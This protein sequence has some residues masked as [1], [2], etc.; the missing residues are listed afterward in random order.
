MASGGSDPPPQEPT[1]TENGV[2]NRRPG[3]DRLKGFN[4]KQESMAS[5]PSSKRRILLALMIVNTMDAMGEFLMGVCFPY[6]M[7]PPDPSVPLTQEQIDGGYG[8][9]AN[10]AVKIG[11][12][13]AMNLGPQFYNAGQFLSSIASG[14]LARAIG[15]RR[16][17]ILYTLGGCVGMVLAGLSKDWGMWAFFGMRMLTG[18]FGGSLVVVTSLVVDVSDGPEDQESNM[19]QVVGPTMILGLVAGPVIG[20][21]IK[22]PDN[23]RLFWPLYIGAI[24][25]FI[26]F[27][28]VFAII[29]D[30]PKKDTQ[31]E[32]LFTKYEEDEDKEDRTAKVGFTKFVAIFWLACAMDTA[33]Q[34]AM[35]M[36]NNV[37]FHRFPWVRSHFTEVIII[38]AVVV[39]LVMPLSITMT[40]FLGYAYTAIVGQTL[41][42]VCMFVFYAIATTNS[43][44]I[45]PFMIMFYLTPFFNTIS[46]FN[47][48]NI[49][50]GLVPKK[51]AD[52]WLGYMD[53]FDQVLQA[54]APFLLVTF[55]QD[56][57]WGPYPYDVCT[58]LPASCTGTLAERYVALCPCSWSKDFGSSDNFKEGTFL[59][60]SGI[61]TVLS[62]IPYGVLILKF[63]VRQ[64]GAEVADIPE[65][66]REAM[67][68]YRETGDY[69]W[70]T[71]SQFYDVSMELMRQGAPAP[72][73]RFGNF[74]EDK[75][76]LDRILAMARTDAQFWLSMIKDSKLKWKRGGPEKEELKKMLQME[77]QAPLWSEIPEDSDDFLAWFKDY[78]AFA[79]YGNPCEMPRGWKGILMT[80]FPMMGLEYG[81]KHPKYA[82]DPIPMMQAGE[83]FIRG[84]L[85]LLKMHSDTSGVLGGLRVCSVKTTGMV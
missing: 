49:I 59:L 71:A 65:S 61:V 66:E 13:I 32:K 44:G 43:A 77:A 70:L 74:E 83:K 16:T 53:S 9:F 68:T 84:H 78:L 58:P 73:A 30:P 8:A 69:T 17:L 41:C 81:P 67:K 2:Q 23:T 45:V 24:S 57:E 18:C 10:E 47:K 60:A 51:D 27:L 34:V 38:F 85:A 36:V 76:H 80:A 6:I 63:P 54:L 7:L 12:T 22:G 29:Y 52:H 15:K 72:K 3:L 50:T 20:N 64:A 35:P 31:Q 5:N 14:Y 39:A 37:G 28:I 56:E 82:E 40:R 75:P 19:G 4:A 25:E 21:A 42:A 55:L 62:M 46:G 11:T 48:Q 79:G 33:A 26:A 1:S